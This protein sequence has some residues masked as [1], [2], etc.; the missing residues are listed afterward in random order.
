LSE[1]P[2]PF[3]ALDWDP[4]RAREFTDRTADIWMEVLERL[5]SLPIAKH[6]TSEQVRQAVAIPVPDEP[7]PDDELFSYLRSIALDWSAYCGHP[8]F[9][10]YVTG[11]GTVPGAAADLLAA[12]L[13]MNAGGWQLSPSA[14]EIELHL[15]RWFAQE[16]F[17]LPEGSGG[18][19]TS[20][21]AMANFVALKVARD[22]KAGWDVRTEG[23]AGGP[24][25]VIYLSTETHVV[26]E[27]A[28]DMLGIGIKN[29]RHLQTGPDCRM[30]VDEL[31]A[32]IE[33]DVAAGLK[34]LAV[35]GSAGT[36]ATGAVDPLDRIA[37]LCE[38]LDVWFHIDAAYGGPAAL[39][40]DLRPQF[41]GIERADSIAFDPHKWLYT[42]HSGGCVLLRDAGLLSKSFDAV[43]SYV[44]QEKDFT[45]HGVD[46]GRMGPQ[47]SRS[48]SALKIW[49][50]LLAHGRAAYS[51]RISHDAELAR[52]LGSR[53]GEREGFELTAPVGLS[54]C[55]FRYVPSDLVG[56]AEERE[57]YLNHLNTRLMT[58]IQG[59]GR[60]YC[61][62]AV[63]DGLFT[64]RACI[65]NYRTE[66]DQMDLLLDVAQELGSA[67]DATMRPEGLRS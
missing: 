17:G 55:C 3:P 25:L 14:T 11:A 45:G 66:A 48:F 59:D 62:N 36:V 46:L 21:G 54:I 29:V 50:S 30:P 8:G 63:L 60:V 49:V 23:I 18:E 10:A 53:V 15:A 41:S 42:P 43:A 27:R 51:K 58:E 1:R 6:W 31:R 56:N 2:A 57:T 22:R 19:L 28:A 4:K 35:V 38:E 12:G 20:G 47:F 44:V 9:M 32:Q 13:N 16:M 40:D 34:P 33:R 39:A 5:P 26:S 37:D 65:V 67:L 52:Y 61:S 24:P 64:L 7:L